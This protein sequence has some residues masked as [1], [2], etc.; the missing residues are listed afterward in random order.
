MNELLFL[1]DTTAEL[2]GRRIWAILRGVRDGEK[3]TAEARQEA[4]ANLELS[5]QQLDKAERLA[6]AASALGE[7]APYGLMETRER[8]VRA[9]R[10]KVQDY[11][12]ALESAQSQ[13]RPHEPCDLPLTT[14]D[15]ILCRLEGRPETPEGVPLNDRVLSGYRD[16]DSWVAET[17]GG[18][19]VD[20]LSGD[21]RKARE[22]MLT[23]E[24][25][26]DRKLR[27]TYSRIPSWV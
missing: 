22:L 4:S 5:R 15:V 27:D 18:R 25:D 13:V 24:S 17:Y 23:G 1:S 12:R 11:E 26:V 3:R 20:L 19:K 6:Y 8:A 21:T 16:G 2:S 10:V 7:F 9:A 14:E